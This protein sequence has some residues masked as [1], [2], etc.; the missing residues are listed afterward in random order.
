[1]AWL[2]PDERRIIA[3]VLALLAGG[4]L[5]LGWRTWRTPR[6]PV[7]LDSLDL[8]FIQRGGAL[9]ADTLS[10]GEATPHPTAPAAVAVVDLNRADSVALLDLPGIGPAKAAAILAWRRAHGRF[11]RVDDLLEVSGIG[12]GTLSRLKERVTVGGAAAAAVDSAARRAAE[13]G[14]A[15]R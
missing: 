7:P 3:V 4:Y 8:A 14:A 1:M 15:A 11:R 9:S 10:R 6:L 2:T 12:P 5:A 13:R